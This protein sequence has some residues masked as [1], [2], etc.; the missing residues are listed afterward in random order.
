MDEDGGHLALFTKTRVHPTKG[1]QL[2]LLTPRR[3]T[4]APQTPVHIP[5]NGT[6]AAARGD[7]C[8]SDPFWSR[9][10]PLVKLCL[11]PT[12]A[13]TRVVIRARSRLVKGA[14]PRILLKTNAKQ[15]EGHPTHMR[16][17]QGSIVSSTACGLCVA[18]LW[19]PATPSACPSAWPLA[20][21]PVHSRGHPLPLELFQNL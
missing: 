7:V 1:L 8:W 6:T 16:T 10:S 3:Q 11:L 21:P 20:W 14:H 5:A 17:V 18:L 2:D 13:K 19:L 4:Q 15:S 12:Y 9:R